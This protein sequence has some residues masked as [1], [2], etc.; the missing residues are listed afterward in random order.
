MSKMNGWIENLER[1]HDLLCD[2]S[3]C[4]DICFDRCMSRNSNGK[5]QDNTIQIRIFL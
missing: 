4:M 5:I 1:V 2:L 3:E